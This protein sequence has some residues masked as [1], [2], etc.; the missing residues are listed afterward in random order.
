LNHPVKRWPGACTWENSISE[1]GGRS[2][3]GGSC[4]LNAVW[5]ICG[6]PGVWDRARATAVRWPN[7]MAGRMRQVWSVLLTRVAAVETLWPGTVAASRSMVARRPLR[8]G[9]MGI[10]GEGCA[11]GKSR[12]KPDRPLP[13]GYGTWHPMGV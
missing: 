11:K 2:M 7:R 12:P 10:L 6:G 13:E 4:S 3:V 8:K 9:C 1:L 5:I